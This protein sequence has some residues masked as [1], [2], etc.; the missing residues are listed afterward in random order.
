MAT[1]D[2]QTDAPERL[3]LVGCVVGL[4]L[5]VLV[6]SA[7][8]FLIQQQI[9]QQQD[10]SHVVNLAGRQRMLSQRVAKSALRIIS[11]PDA[12]VREGAR[13]ELAS[14]LNLLRRTH[15]G[16][17]EGDAE[18]QLPGTNSKEVMRLFREI[19]P[20]YKQI[21]LTSGRILE[22]AAEYEGSLASVK[23]AAASSAALI[24][25]ESRF[26]EGMNRIVFQ[27]DSE[28][29]RRVSRTRDMENL[30]YL[31]LLTILL[32][33]AVFIF[34]PM[35][36]RTRRTLRLLRK[37]ERGLISTRRQ[38]EASIHK[39]RDAQENLLEV[40]KK[41]VLSSVVAGVT[42]DVNTPIGIG[43]TAASTLQEQT[44]K[45]ASRYQQDQVTRRDMEDYQATAI[46]S[47][48]IILQN[49][50][51]ASELIR[52]FKQVAVDQSSEQR[53]RFNLHQYLDDIVLAMSAR[54]RTTEHRINIRCPEQIEMDSFPGALY[55]VISNLIMN[56]LVHGFE[57]I[58]VGT[59]DIDVSQQGDQLE[60]IY[61][62]DGCGLSESASKQFFNVFFTTKREQGGT[63]IGTHVIKSL[64]EDNLGGEIRLASDPGVGIELVIR[65][66]VRSGSENPS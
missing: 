63:G 39:L 34:R 21:L 27:Y 47:T 35:I 64:V 38:L 20:A 25:N 31:L 60:I 4:L 2:R 61:R 33:E 22:L 17:L 42:H 54:L 13:D 55:Q 8:H 6:A 49:L 44:R 7:G 46:E 40:E 30:L 48:E 1:S 51:R 52:N 29:Q 53:R 24:E 14:S 10:G 3:L 12:L 37:N 36:Q 50:Q 41:A 26:L 11:A 66:P 5:I 62:D 65:I 19:E 23:D 56:S 59:I 43:V 15:I 16:L 9:L 18:L 32:L 45:F 57:N 28:S 58:R